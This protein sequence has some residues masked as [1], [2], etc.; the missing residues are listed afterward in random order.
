MKKKRIEIKGP[1][2][3]DRIVFALTLPDIPKKDDREGPFKVIKTKEYNLMKNMIDTIPGYTTQIRKQNI[4][5]K[6]MK[7]ELDL[8][9]VELDTKEKQQMKL[10]AKVG[11]LTT[12][13]KREK[14]KN[15]EFLKAVNEL[16]DKLEESMSNKYLVK[17]I[18]SGRRPKTQTM[19]LKSCTVQ[20]KIAMK[21][22]GE[23]K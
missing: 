3:I 6:K 12:S 8:K 4:D 10:I 23:N 17:K 16:E 14:K 22:H 15:E 20:S 1:S 11:G 21:V 18:P 9:I 13:L 5:L 2:I 7:E 19:K